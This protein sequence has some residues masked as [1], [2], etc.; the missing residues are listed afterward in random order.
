MRRR[1]TLHSWSPRSSLRASHQSPKNGPLTT[2]GRLHSSRLSEHADLSQ[3]RRIVGNARCSG[4]HPP[5]WST[6]NDDSRCHGCPAPHAM[7]P[8]SQS[9]EATPVVCERLAGNRD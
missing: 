5:N 2:G 8:H 3:V 7:T 4:G 9:A 1:G 6:K